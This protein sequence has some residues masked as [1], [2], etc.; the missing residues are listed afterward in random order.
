MNCFKIIHFTF[1]LTLCILL[2]VSLTQE[3]LSPQILE[4]IEKSVTITPDIKARMNA[5]ANNE[6]KKLALNLEVF[7]DLDH[8]F[9]Y[10]IKTGE[11]TNQKSS[12]RCWLFTSLNVLRPAVMKK[13]N[14]THSN[15]F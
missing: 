3:T 5:V 10:R 14:M 15:R 7:Q 4:K 1:F 13:H 9:A 12:G 2:Q 11:V 8:L 6:I